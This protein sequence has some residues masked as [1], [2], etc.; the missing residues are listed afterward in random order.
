MCGPP[1]PRRC[2]HTP[3]TISNSTSSPSNTKKCTGLQTS[4]NPEAVGDYSNC[5]LAPRVINE[6]RK[7]YR[8]AFDLEQQSVHALC[9]D[10]KRQSVKHLGYG[11]CVDN[12]QGIFYPRKADIAI[13]ARVVLNMQRKW[14]FPLDTATT[15]SFDEL[16]RLAT[17][18]P[19]STKEL[20]QR[21]LLAAV[22][23]GLMSF[24]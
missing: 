13:V 3:H 8:I 21:L 12:V 20:T 10:S 15:A 4:P 23:H 9:T 6:G 1:A 5:F 19:Q 7:N 17:S 11:N 2:A 16:Y 24:K 18:T 22:D 14:V